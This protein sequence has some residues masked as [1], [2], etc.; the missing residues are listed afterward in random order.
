MNKQGQTLIIFV[1]LIPMILTLLAIVVDVGL[2]T[3]EVEKA[4]GVVDIAIKE[5]LTG[6][7]E[8]KI[9]ELI[10]MNNIPIDNLEIAMKENEIEIELQYEMN[11]LFGKI[12]NIQQYDVI[13]RRVGTL[14]ND[15]IQIKNKE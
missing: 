8:E 12:I 13:V 15:K 5:Y 14:Q 2:L 3:N 11:S 4:T 7:N 10:Q 9:K 6:E 1:I